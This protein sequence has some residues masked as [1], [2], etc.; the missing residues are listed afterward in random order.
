MIIKDRYRVDFK[1]FVWEV[2]RFHGENSGLVVAEI[3]LEHQDQD[4]P[5]PDWIDKEVSGDPRYYNASLVRRPYSQW[6]SEPFPS[7]A[8]EHDG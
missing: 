2:D 4:V 5:L 7:G 1:G 6:G 8:V 3:E